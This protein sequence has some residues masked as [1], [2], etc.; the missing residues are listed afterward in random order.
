MKT[1]YKRGDF[2]EIRRFVGHI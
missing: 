1:L 2:S